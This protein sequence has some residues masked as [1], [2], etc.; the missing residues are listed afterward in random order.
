MVRRY[1]VLVIGLLLVLATLGAWLYS[2][3]NPQG[4]GLCHPIA[5]YIGRTPTVQ[6]CQSYEPTVFAV[7]IALIAIVVPILLYLAGDADVEFPFLG[8]TVLVTR[9]GKQASEMLPTPYDLEQRGD[10]WLGVVSTEESGGGSGR[11]G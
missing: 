3:L 11:H 9:S 6:D 1:A 5:L 10:E 2:L 7:P 8:K 4:F